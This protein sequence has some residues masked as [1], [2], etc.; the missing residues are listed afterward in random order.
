MLALTCNYHHSFSLF[1]SHYRSIY[2]STLSCPVLS[3]PILSYP[4]LSYP[5]YP[6]YPIHP[7]YLSILCMTIHMSLRL[8]R[9]IHLVF[10][11]SLS[12]SLSGTLTAAVLAQGKDKSAWLT[13]FRSRVKLLQRLA[14]GIAFVLDRQIDRSINRSID[15]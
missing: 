8:S 13:F 7:I 9:C 2:L 11:L 4:I 12:P 15:R 14:V 5:S 10:S 1:L 3:C 6:S